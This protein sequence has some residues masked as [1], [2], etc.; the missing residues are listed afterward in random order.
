MKT[1]HLFYVSKSLVAFRKNIFNIR[2]LLPQ[3]VVRVTEHICHLK[4]RITKACNCDNS[5][6]GN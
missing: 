5:N 1:L 4:H 6:L 3:S 2:L